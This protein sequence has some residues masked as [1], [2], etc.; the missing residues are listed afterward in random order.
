LVVSPEPGPQGHARL[1][2]ELGAMDFLAALAD[3]EPGAQR[4]VYL[5]YD[6]LDRIINPVNFQTHAHE[7]LVC[8][9][10]A[11]VE[12]FNDIMK[13]EFSERP[14]ALQAW[15]RK[16]CEVKK[17]AAQQTRHA[18]RPLNMDSLLARVKSAQTVKYFGG[19]SLLMLERFYTAGVA[20]KIDCS[21]QAVRFPFRFVWSRC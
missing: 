5:N 15:Y 17:R 10:P 16:C 1:H 2:G 13:K 14:G 20:R 18:V 21:I 11:E 19:A 7:E 3:W 9:T 6:A 8:R 4:E 12:A